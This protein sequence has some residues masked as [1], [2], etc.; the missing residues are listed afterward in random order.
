MKRLLLWILL[1]SFNFSFAQKT[2]LL[3][4]D[5]VF[6]GQ[7]MHEGWWVLIKGNPRRYCLQP[8]LLLQPEVT[9]RKAW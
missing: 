2:T 1:F 6:D 3:K 8:V 9:G 7:Q 4:P 5:R